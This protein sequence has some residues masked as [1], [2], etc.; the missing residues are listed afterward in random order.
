M[1]WL[2][3]V[4]YALCMFIVMYLVALNVFDVIKLS[5]STPRTLNKMD[6]FVNKTCTKVEYFQNVVTGFSLHSHS[7]SGCHSVALEY[8]CFEIPSNLRL[9]FFI[10]FIDSIIVLELI[11]MIIL[12]RRCIFFMYWYLVFILESYQNSHQHSLVINV[13]AV[14]Y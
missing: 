2:S 14:M 13:I 1:K 12:S 10:I 7:G 9:L 5:H 4:S 3:N 11:A 8:Q 6:L